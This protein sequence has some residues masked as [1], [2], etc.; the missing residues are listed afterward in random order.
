MSVA[1]VVGL[2]AGR[3]VSAVL[4][5]LTSDTCGHMIMK[6]PGPCRYNH[7]ITVVRISTIIVNGPLQEGSRH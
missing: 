6:L 2:Q 3:L 7:E 5:P 1:P 4:Q